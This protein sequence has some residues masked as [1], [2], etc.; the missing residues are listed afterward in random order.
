MEAAQEWSAPN[1]EA[2]QWPSVSH[3]V[4]KKFLIEASGNSFQHEDTQSIQVYYI[5]SFMHERVCKTFEYYLLDHPKSG[6][7]KTGPA[8]PVPAPLTEGG[9]EG[10]EWW[11]SEGRGG[12]GK[13]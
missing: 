6:P 5:H 10:G 13:G 3:T 12:K 9:S 7:A 1:T 2:V 11:V 4:R 8:R